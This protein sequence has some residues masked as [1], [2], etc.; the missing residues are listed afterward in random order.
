MGFFLNQDPISTD[1]GVEQRE[2]FKWKHHTYGLLVCFFFS[3]GSF[4]WGYDN[5]YFGGLPVIQIFLDKYG[6]E[7]GPDGVK[8]MSAPLLS[9]LSSLIQIGD[10]VGCMLAGALGIYTGRKGGLLIASFF[11]I[12]G[13]TLQAAAP[14]DGVFLGGRIILGVGV[15]FLTHCV[16]LYL[17]ECSPVRIRG[18]VVGMFQCTLAFSGLLA[19]IITQFTSTYTNSGAYLIPICFQ[20]ICPLIFLTFVWFV[21]DSPRYYASVGKFDRARE[22]LM[23]LHRTHPTYDPTP[24]MNELILDA[25]EE[26]KLKG[27]GGWGEL[28]TDPVE[29]RKLINTIGTFYSQQSTA[30][31]FIAT[32]STVFA[33]ELKAADPFLIGIATSLLSFVGVLLNFTYSSRVDRKMI[34][35]PASCAIAVCMLLVGALSC[36]PQASYLVPSL[37]Y[38]KAIIGFACIAI[39]IFNLSWGPL[40]WVIATEVCPGPN[41]TRIM[42]VSVT[43][44]WIFS[45]LVTFTMPYLFTTAGLGAKIGFIYFGYGLTGATF[46]FF[47]IGETRNR[48][49]EEIDEMYRMRIPARKW[50]TYK[51]KIGKEAMELTEGQEKV[52]T[53]SPTTQEK[54]A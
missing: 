12:L 13:V 39:F 15:G 16:P 24:Q 45:W 2:A 38:G 29:R 7:T 1:G 9:E 42:A 8:T 48:T 32:Y 52:Q 23:K 6:D 37:P 3:W 26:K 43:C 40:A 36:G 49:L 18:I 46:M 47:C 21:P 4:Q 11:T 20:Y 28:F 41:R 14:N 53:V 19:S 33:S 22:V 5:G 51:T 44:F 50:K 35:I 31:S 10:V 54:I 17:S 30:I 25:E 27:M 34:V